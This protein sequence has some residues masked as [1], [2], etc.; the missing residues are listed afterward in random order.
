MCW[1]YDDIKRKYY[2]G[3][4]NIIFVIW[5]IWEIIPHYLIKNTQFL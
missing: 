4:K 3:K 5:Y 2:R 1:A